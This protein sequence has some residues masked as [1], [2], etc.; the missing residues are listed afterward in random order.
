MKV[1]TS[2]QRVS[3]FCFEGLQVPLQRVWCRGRERE[4]LLLLLTS[5]GRHGQRGGAAGSIL[6]RYPRRNEA[7]VPRLVGHFTLPAG[8]GRATLFLLGGT[9][10]GKSGVEITGTS[11]IHVLSSSSP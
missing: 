4:N 11:D 3:R 2:R 1:D 10:A 7:K 5:L 6:G 8:D 9:A